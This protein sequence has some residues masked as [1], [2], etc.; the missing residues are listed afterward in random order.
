MNQTNVSVKRR[1]YI[2]LDKPR[3][4][5]ACEEQS[6]HWLILYMNIS[7]N[8]W[9]AFNFSAKNRTLST[10]IIGNYQ[11]KNRFSLGKD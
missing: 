7:E 10:N 6:H 2:E 8:K 11:L 5:S 3:A 9:M 4:V 1:E